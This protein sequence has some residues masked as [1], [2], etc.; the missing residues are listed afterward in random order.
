MP[1]RLIQGY[2]ESEDGGMTSQHSSFQHCQEV[3]FYQ[4]CR[5]AI[6]FP[7]A[8]V[9]G[10]SQ[11]DL[12]PGFLRC[13]LFWGCRSWSDLLWCIPQFHAKWFNY[14]HPQHS[15]EVS[16]WLTKMRPGWPGACR[17]ISPYYLL[18]GKVAFLSLCSRLVN[19]HVWEKREEKSSHF[20]SKA[21]F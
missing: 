14:S 13:L 10:P 5:S 9:G 16:C 3:Y 12:A 1:S 20:Q 15:G 21:R 8:P 7:V 4:L 6:T 19:H 18:E 11:L 17:K 2:L